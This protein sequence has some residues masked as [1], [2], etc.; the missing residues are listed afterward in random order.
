MVDMTQVMADFH[1]RQAER[2]LQAQ[3][4][5]EHLKQAVI[6]LLGA[7]GI[8]RVEVRF[9]SWVLQQTVP[10]DGCGDSGAVEQCECFDA[11]MNTVPC[12]EVAVAPFEFEVAR[13]PT[14]EA[15]MLLAAAL[16][17]LTYLA[18]ERFHPGW[19]INDGSCGLLVIEVPEA[20]FVLECSLRYTGYDE[21]S[22][23]L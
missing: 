9:E 6:G 10:A 13:E 15:P 1:E 22:T 7:A 5:T 18:L 14:G 4:E 3:T 2:A 8:A 11:A 17:S 20:S 23:G 12:P 19:E 16:D 21:H